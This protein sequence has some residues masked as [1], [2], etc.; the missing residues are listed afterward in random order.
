MSSEKHLIRNIPNPLKRDGTSQDARLPDILKPES[1]S[2]DGK[3]I[4]DWLREARKYAELL[5]YYNP[6]NVIDGDWSKFI[7][8]DITSLISLLEEEKPQALRE[9]YVK[10]LDRMSVDQSEENTNVLGESLVVLIGYADQINKWFESSK[11]DESLEE[12]EELLIQTELQ[13]LIPSII[14]DGYS[15]IIEYLKKAEEENIPINNFTNQAVYIPLFEEQWPLLPIVGQYQPLAEGIP[16]TSDQ[17]AEEKE[18]LISLYDRFYEVHVRLFQQAEALLNNSLDNFPA[19]KPH[20]ALFIAC[21]KLFQFAQTSLNQLSKNHLDFYYQEVLKLKFRDEVAD[22]VHLI[23]ELAQNFPDSLIG[24]DRVF[25]AG[26]DQT[27]QDLFYA[28]DGELVVNKAQLGEDGLKSLNIQ[29]DYSTNDEGEQEFEIVNIFAAPDADSEDGLGEDLLSADKQW[30]TFGTSEPAKTPHAELGFAIASPMFYLKEGSRTL[31]LSLQ[32]TNLPQLIERYGRAVLK[33]ELRLNVKLYYTSPEGWFLIPNT[34]VNVLID[35]DIKYIIEL[36]QEDPAFVAYTED[37]FQSSFATEY[38][39]LRF[40]MNNDGLDASGNLE[41]NLAAGIED[42]E[43]NRLYL[44]NEFAKVEEGNGSFRILKANGENIAPDLRS[45][46]LDVENPSE[47]SNIDLWAEVDVNAINSFPRSS[48]ELGLDAGLGLRYV[49]G[50]L[51][52]VG[53]IIYKANAEFFEEISPRDPANTLLWINLSEEKFDVDHVNEYQLGDIV[54][55][56]GD[57]WRKQLDYPL[58]PGQTVPGG[59]EMVWIKVAGFDDN[60]RYQEGASIIVN[61][62][63]YRATLGTQGVSPESNSK[64]VIPFD[65]STPSVYS[66]SNRY[67]RDDVVELSE[68]SETFIY[69][70]QALAAQGILPSPG[71]SSNLKLW[72]ELD[73]FDSEVTYGKPPSGDLIIY[74]SGKVYKLIALE[75]ESVPSDEEKIW[76]EVP[77]I[78]FDPSTNEKGNLVDIRTLGNFI[79]RLN[80]VSALQNGDTIQP[81]PVLSAALTIW[82]PEDVETEYPSHSKG[83]IV[84]SEGRLYR[85]EVLAIPDNSQGPEDVVSILIW[86]SLLVSEYQS[87][88]EYNED[89]YVT[90]D[91]G[92]GLKLYQAL[93]AVEAEVEPS[94]DTF[95]NEVTITPPSDRYEKD[96]IVLFE[97]TYYKSNASN[98]VSPEDN[99]RILSELGLNDFDSNQNNFEADYGQYARWE[100]AFYICNAKTRDIAPVVFDPSSNGE[101][102]PDQFVWYPIEY[103]FYNSSQFNI[104]QYA[105]AGGLFFRANASTS[106]ISPI[107]DEPIWKYLP[108]IDYQSASEFDEGNYVQY[109]NSFYR[110][111]A[112]TDRTYRPDSGESIWKK[113]NTNSVIVLTGAVEEAVEVNDYIKSTDDRYYISRV[114]ATLNVDRIE[115]LLKMDIWVNEGLSAYSPI[116][117]YQ[118]GDFVTF[119]SSIFQAQ[120]QFLD[121]SPDSNKLLWEVFDVNVVQ[122][123][124]SERFYPIGQYALLT[125]NQNSTYYFARAGI[126][127]ISPKDKVKLWEFVQYERDILIIS[128]Y[129]ESTLYTPGSFVILNDMIYRSKTQNFAVQPGLDPTKWYLLGD[130]EPYQEARA[131]P[132]YTNVRYQGLV[133]EALKMVPTNIFPGSGE[134]SEYWGRVIGSYPYKYFASLNFEIIEIMVDVRG[135]KDLVLEN[136]QGI[137]DPA[138]P[139]NP[140]GTF[141]REKNNFYIGSTEIFQKKLE[142]DELFNLKLKITWADLPKIA[143][144]TY[145]ANY[146]DDGN[147]TITVNLDNFQAKI[148]S[149]ENN[150]WSWVDTSETREEVGV[151]LFDSTTQNPSIPTDSRE[152]SILTDILTKRDENLESFTDYDISLKRGF[153]RLELVRDFLHPNYAK[154]IA[155]GALEEKPVIPNEPY[156]PL[157]STFSVDYKSSEQIVYRGRKRSDLESRVEQF[158][159]IHP[160]GQ[161]EFLPIP[162]D[163]QA[164][165]ISSQ[166]L[167]P[168]FDVRVLTTEGDAVQENGEDKLEAPAGTLYIG[169]TDVEPLRNISI[170]F[171]VAESSENP[172]LDQEKVVW[173][174]LENNRWIEFPAGGV[175]SDTSNDL[176]TSGIVQFAMPRKISTDNTILPSGLFWIKASV[177]FFSDSVPKMIAIR[178]QA[179]QAS[180]RNTGQN[181]PNHLAAPLLGGTISQFQERLASIK[182]VE[183]PYASFEGKLGEQESEFYTRISERLR[184]KGRGI[185][186]FDIERLVLEEFP[187]LYKVKC[188][189]HSTDNGMYHGSNQGSKKILTREHAPGFVKVVVIPNLR[190]QNAVNPLQPRASKNTL[191]EIK[192]FLSQRMSDFVKLEVVN[193]IFEEVKV[194][195]KV[196]FDPGRDKEFYRKQLNLDLRNFLSPWLSDEAADLSFTAVFHLSLILAFMDGLEYVDYIVDMSLVHTITSLDEDGN[197]VEFCR[198]NLQEI[199]PTTSGSVLVSAE[200]HDITPIL[201]LKTA[202]Q[203]R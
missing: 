126:N 32:F 116:T 197:E 144:G 82:E 94:D 131:Y 59:D 202:S 62:V 89:E 109:E 161:A 7:E 57:I 162:D 107:D 199:Q 174:Y 25:L 86:E 118:K 61:G 181:D 100:D 129:S 101:D 4:D 79:F 83:A 164:G 77:V 120:A 63:T 157:I 203:E 155:I 150:E 20:M 188:L 67:L 138:K 42:Y 15:K 80:A 184:H 132:Q 119:N 31:T 106:A 141:P 195:A 90:F 110:V 68:L 6:R 49:A 123:F 156:T 146:I 182:T 122:E 171:Q 167:V 165:P 84:F 190:N 71:E 196:A 154:S 136:D 75:T 173:S 43:A 183:Q 191:S 58:A 50:S 12:V 64:A 41:F 128:P 11:V 137:I 10:L 17:I 97:D 2:I 142:G 13:R 65:G 38:P 177:V 5:H 98:D 168:Q 39:V 55:Y 14:D 111:N 201:Q 34:Q 69:R 149:L 85:Q 45:L 18:M 166:V 187:Q 93:A 134:D 186:I 99:L 91:D 175:I 133:Y 8:S 145:Y 158:F 115:S 160:F 72:T 66:S 169:L 29:K 135:V 113:L 96:D 121:I 103:R 140:F 108:S 117:L 78:A 76:S 9:N 30:Y 179:L 51:T 176:L 139:F 48:P 130:I 70:L 112:T 21:L 163:G 1:I 159:H 104:G 95:W 105:R 44:I 19:H 114:F 194:V 192:E 22:K 143:I 27:Q 180:Y 54:E 37:L 46:M 185:N 87:S 170:L 26:K 16:L 200:E 153:I 148:Y 151:L 152:I 47:S 193:P 56:Q 40:I 3:N 52:E 33:T 73:E 28:S 178:T 189:N 147:N 60:Q 35:T 81:N 88:K 172:L 23:F 36:T 102:F 127:G 92:S 53:G 24:K 125:E 124:D 198:T 74:D